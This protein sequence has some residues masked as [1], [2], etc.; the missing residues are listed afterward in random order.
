M[1]FHKISP[2]R[3]E[4]TGWT[5]LKHANINNILPMINTNTRSNAMT[6]PL[7]PPQ[8]YKIVR[9]NFS[10]PLKNMI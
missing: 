1:P 7:S 8:A 4:K 10:P 2:S 6:S 5:S 3:K 9:L